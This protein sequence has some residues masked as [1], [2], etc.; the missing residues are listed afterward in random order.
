MK[1]KNNEKEK[2]HHITFAAAAAARIRMEL[3]VRLL[4]I[5]A[6]SM[7]PFIPLLLFGRTA[8]GYSFGFSLP[9]QHRFEEKAPDGTIV[10]E[11]GFATANGLYLTTK[12]ATDKDGN[13]VVRER[14]RETLDE[15]AARRR[16][17]RALEV[18]ERPTPPP[19]T[20]TVRP[21]VE[22]RFNYTTT[23]DERP[24]I[25][26]HHHEETGFSDGSKR[27]S[28]FWDAADGQ[29][30][31]VT[32]EAGAEGRGFSA[33]RRKVVAATGGKSDSTA[34]DSG[35]SSHGRGRRRRRPRITRRGRRR[36]TRRR[37]P[38]ERKGGTA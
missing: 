3:S 25:R 27:G 10:G 1:R 2:N 15:Y 7:W 20:T 24:L 28:Y 5:L 22:Y 18:T 23:D 14:T 16:G 34:E 38:K 13:F 6:L 12:Y 11:F 33:V 37:G 26:K 19:P 29:R 17:G 21:K 8:E 35:I 4:P 32:Y 36:R 30:F 9:T 31:L